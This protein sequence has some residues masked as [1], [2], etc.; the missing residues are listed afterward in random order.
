M[1]YTKLLSVALVICWA[2]EAFAQTQKEVL[3]GLNEVP[4]LVSSKS[5]VGKETLKQKHQKQRREVI[6]MEFKRFVEQFVRLPAKIIRGGR[7]LT[8]RLLSWTESLDAFNRWL[9]V[10]LE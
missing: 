10:A 4:I 3:K 8:V 2:G 9:S 7:Q 5:A 6:R 1:Y